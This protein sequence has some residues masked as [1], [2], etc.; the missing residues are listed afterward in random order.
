MMKSDGEVRLT[1]LITV[2]TLQKI[3]TSFSKMARMAALVTDENGV[4]LTEGSSFSEL[5]INYCRKSPIE[6]NGARNET[7]TALQEYLKP[8]S[9]CPIT[10]M[11]ILW[12]SP[13][14]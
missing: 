4:P 12:I 9:P 3:Q 13:R 8:G 10:A 6:E 14:R 5:C 11:Q 2:E 7:A 1:D